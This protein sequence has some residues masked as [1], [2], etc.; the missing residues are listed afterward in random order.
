VLAFSRLLND[1]EVVTVVNMTAAPVAV[2]VIVDAILH[3]AGSRFVLA[4]SNR[5]GAAQP[6]PVVELGRNRPLTIH[7]VDGGVS[8]GPAH[9]LHV[10]LQA[11]EAQILTEPL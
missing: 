5:A 7:E 9:A 1:E 11:R 4:F 3:P 2:F 8:H 10:S 6:Q